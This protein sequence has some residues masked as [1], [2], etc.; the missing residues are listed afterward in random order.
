MHM[1][2]ITSTGECFLPIGCSCI[3][4]FQLE[5]FASAAPDRYRASGSPFRWNIITPE[6]TARLLEAVQADKYFSLLDVPDDI[7]WD[8]SWPCSRKIDGL[9]FW[10]IAKDVGAGNRMEARVLLQDHAVFAQ[11]K[12]KYDRLLKKLFELPRETVFVWSNIQPNL[13][14]AI[15]LVERVTWDDFILTDERMGAIKHSLR[16]LGFDDPA[17]VWICRQEDCAVRD[18]MP[19]IHLMQL[20]RSED[21]KGEAGLFD[22]IYRRCLSKSMDDSAREQLHRY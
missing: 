6:A 16:A 22:E 15:E 2:T 20:P 1:L 18:P 17:C 10:H 19:D 3:N 21:Y 13:K 8:A 9:Y 4:Q 12:S 7:V 14:A 11:F 5:F